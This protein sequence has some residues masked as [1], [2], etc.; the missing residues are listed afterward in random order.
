[1]R[2]AY[3]LAP[4]HTRLLQDLHVL[5][6][7]GLG[8]PEA[9]G[10]IP[11]GGRPCGEPFHDPAT[12]GVGESLEGIINHK[13]NSSRQ[14]NGLLGL[15]RCA[16]WTTRDGQAGDEVRS[17]PDPL[18]G[19][20]TKPFRKNGGALA[21][22]HVRTAMRDDLATD[23]PRATDEVAVFRA[24]PRTDPASSLGVYATASARS[25]SGCAFSD[26]AH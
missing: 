20:R 23:G 22:A 11:D 3:D 19:C 21:E 18:G 24:H 12:D 26:V 10:R 4:H 9:S 14:A 7:R 5:G 16:P 1:M 15:R 2:P 17:G 8:Y 6:D 25:G 13:V